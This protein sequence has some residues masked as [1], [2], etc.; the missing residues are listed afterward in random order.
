M[1]KQVSRKSSRV[2]QVASVWVKRR[3]GPERVWDAYRLLLDLP[4]QRT[5]DHL[6]L[7][8]HHEREAGEGSAATGPSFGAPAGG[9]RE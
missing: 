6:A 9:S 3:D 8:P 4:P 5:R 2:W 1:A 7:L